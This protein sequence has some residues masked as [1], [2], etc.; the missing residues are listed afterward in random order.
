MKP[1]FIY[2]LI[3]FCMLA[4]KSNGQL[5]QKLETQKKVSLTNEWWSPFLAELKIEIKDYSTFRY[6]FINGS[7]ET[8][9]D[10]LMI[11]KNGTAILNNTGNAEGKTG[12]FEVYY[13]QVFKA[14]SDYEIFYNKMEFW[15]V[16]DNGKLTLKKEMKSEEGKY[17][18]QFYKSKDNIIFTVDLKR[19]SEY[20]ESIK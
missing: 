18:K 15:E 11:F 9:S 13:F 10:T 4:I 1:K 8:K 20:E 12:K 6:F 16:S 2:P 19:D 5:E 14:K 17:L 3:A 7:L